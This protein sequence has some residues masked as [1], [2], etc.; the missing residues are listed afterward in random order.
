MN[1]AAAYE[2]PHLLGPARSPLG[3]APPPFG[4]YQAEAAP[5]RQLLLTGQQGQASAKQA[6]EEMAVAVRDIGLM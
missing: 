4:V 1:W 2:G 5:V 3:I 6:D